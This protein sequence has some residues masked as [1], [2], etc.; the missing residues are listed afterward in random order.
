M[1]NFTSV[2]EAQLS[3][4]DDTRL[5]LKAGDYLLIPAHTKHPG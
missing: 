1:G 5:K 2:G 3:Y 4:A